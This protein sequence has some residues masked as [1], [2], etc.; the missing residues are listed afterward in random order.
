MNIKNNKFLRQKKIKTLKK[1]KLNLQKIM[2]KIYDKLKGRYDNAK[3][4]I[5]YQF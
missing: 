1:K 3:M 5:I 4:R 2:E